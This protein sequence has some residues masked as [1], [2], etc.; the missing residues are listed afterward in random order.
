MAVR[1]ARA[2]GLDD[3]QVRALLLR[4]GGADRRRA[5]AGRTGPS[6]RAGR[7]LAPRHVPS[8][9]PVPDHGLGDALA[10][11]SLR[12]V[13]RARARAERVRRARERPS[14]GDR[15][16]SRD[17]PRDAGPLGA[18]GGERGRRRSPTRAARRLPPR[19]PRERARRDDRRISAHSRSSSH[20]TSGPCA[21]SR[22]LG[23]IVFPAATRSSATAT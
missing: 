15:S 2:S 5:R 7:A 14:P 6:V 19:A 18:R 12:L 13:R 1:T 4:H 3:D 16:D 10:A 21:M 17:P 9:P 20:A 22:K 8:H 23:S 11:P